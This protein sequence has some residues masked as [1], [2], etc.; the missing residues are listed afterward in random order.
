MADAKSPEDCA[1]PNRGSAAKKFRAQQ[2][3]ATSGAPPV[4]LPAVCPLRFVWPAWLPAR[5]ISAADSLVRLSTNAIILCAAI[6][7]REN[8]G[9]SHHIIRANRHYALR[10]GPWPNR[11][12]ASAT[13]RRVKFH[14]ARRDPPTPAVKWQHE[15]GFLRVSVR[16]NY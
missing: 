11:R 5:R 1:H 8:P 12:L 9:R 2:T 16:R 14:R 15:K 10:N 6:S 3:R 7:S 13:R 4:T